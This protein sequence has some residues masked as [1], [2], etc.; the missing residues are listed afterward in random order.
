[1][2]T[3]WGIA[4]MGTRRAPMTPTTEP[5]RP[6]TTT[7]HQFSSIPSVVKKVHSTTSAMPPAPSRL[8][9]RAVFGLARN[10]R[11]RMKPMLAISQ[12]KKVAI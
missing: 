8:P 10:L 9:V 2:A 5:M 3:I 12:T 4:V 11:A 6:P 7:I 1:M